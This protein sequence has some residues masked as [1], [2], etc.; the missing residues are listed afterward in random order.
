MR[1][2]LIH[3]YDDVDLDVVWDTVTTAIPELRNELARLLR[4]LED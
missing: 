3:A 1:D 2:R 4:H